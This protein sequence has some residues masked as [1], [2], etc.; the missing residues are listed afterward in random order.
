M[1]STVPFY[2]H[3]LGEAEIE[4]FREVLNSR[5]LTTGSYVA[6]FES[7][8]SEILGVEET[9]GLTSCTGALH[10]ALLGLGV[11]PGDEVITSTMSF[12]ATATAILEAGAEPVFVDVEPTTGNID[13][14]QIEAAITPRTKAIMPVHLYGLMADMRRIDA[15]AQKHGLFVIEDAAHCVEGMRD[16]IRPGQLSDAAAFSFYATKNLTCGEGGALATRHRDLATK[17][18]RLSHH[19]IT[20]LAFDRH[21]QGIAHWDMPEFGWK[22][23]MSNISAAIL[24]P[25]LPRV[26]PNL[27][28]R[29]ELARLYTEAFESIDGIAL[30]WVPS[31]GVHARHLFPIWLRDRDR[32]DAVAE[33]RARGV[34]C[35]INYRPIHFLTYFKERFGL[36]AGQF[37]HAEWIGERTLSLPFYPRLA[38]ADA[39]RVVEVVRE[40]V[41]T[42][43]PS[44]G[45]SSEAKGR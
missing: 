31:N 22:Y 16:G 8:F 41:G 27:A 44:A 3:D 5:F 1:T 17:V 30:Q 33:L 28:R 23:N 12:V 19:G 37:P 26:E 10:L 14:D 18:R 25:Q 40:V 11:G 4:S 38:T 2:V 45:R 24:L 39:E 35:A 15:I 32:D 13:P 20:K 42:Q 43:G 9:V 6:E 7:K 21:T 29:A 36:R 34:E